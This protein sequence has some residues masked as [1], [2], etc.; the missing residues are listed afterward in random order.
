MNTQTR[1]LRI[2]DPRNKDKEMEVQD[3][4]EDGYKVI[5]KSGGLSI[6]Y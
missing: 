3:E 2:L 5:K 1:K 4:A 6:G